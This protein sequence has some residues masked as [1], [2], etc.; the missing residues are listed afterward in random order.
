MTL[1]GH[2]FFRLEAIVRRGILG[3]ICLMLAACQPEVTLF[4]ALPQSQANAV[5]SAL[6]DA[7]IH[8]RKE[9][10]KD[11]IGV[12][13][14][15]ADA[16]R[17]LTVL[18]QQGLPQMP[19]E[20]LGAVF[21]KEGL[22]AS[23]LA[24]RARYLYA[25]SQELA[26]TLTLMDGVL[27]ARVHVVLAERSG[28]SAVGAPASAAV[29]IK[30]AAEYPID[31][32]L[33]RIRAMVAHGVPGLT[34]DSVSVALFPA[35][36]EEPRAPSRAAINASPFGV[37]ELQTWQL[38]LMALTVLAIGVAGGSLA[39]RSVALGGA[40]RAVITGLSA[41]FKRRDT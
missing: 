29:F 28:I 32:Y 30:H 16:A 35:H 13:V 19:F 21:R 27:A 11:G 37:S 14:A 41:R 9:A 15:G 26:N 20:G 38:V 5:L 18:R 39:R 8:A 23:P 12:V 24:E 33:P 36:S 34:V 2:R 3:L 6:L 7:H 17:A 10:S 1:L 25:L 4:D 40:G 31:I 22:V